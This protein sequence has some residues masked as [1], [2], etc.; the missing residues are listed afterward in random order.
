MGQ[1]RVFLSW[2]RQSLA[3]LLVIVF[4]A[5]VVQ[6]RN[7][8]RAAA[9]L[10]AYQSAVSQDNPALWY[11]LDDPAGTSGAGSVANSGSVGSMWN[12]TPSGGIGFG[13][14]S[15]AN[16]VAG[17][18]DSSG[19]AVFDGSSGVVTVPPPGM[20]IQISSF[21]VEAWARAGSSFSGTG[22]VATLL[23]TTSGMGFAGG[24]A[25]AT[26]NEIGP[27]QSYT[28]TSPTTY[29]NGNWHYLALTDAAG[30]LSLYVD[31]A[32]VAFASTPG[33]LAYVSS[34]AGAIGNNSSVPGSFFGGSIEDVAAYTA[35]LP[36]TRIVAHYD[37]AFSLIGGPVSAADVRGGSCSS[38]QTPAPQT[39]VPKTGDPVDVATGVLSESATDLLTPGRGLGLQFVRSYSSDVAG[40]ASPVGA[41]WTDNYNMG[42][43]FGSG[44][45]PS[46]VSVVTQSGSVVGFAYV[47]SSN[48][49]TAIEPRD[50]ASLVEHSGG[51]WTYIC[52]AKSV[53]D[54][55]A[56]GQLVDEHDL[57]GNTTTLGA[58][59]GGAQTITD[60]AG[61]IWTL[62]YTGALVTRVAEQSGG[63]LPAR[64]VSYSYSGGELTSVTDVNG[65]VTSYGYDSSGRLAE[66]RSARFASDGPLPATPT[67][68][69]G[70]G[71]ADAT[72]MVYDANSRVLCQWDP[73]GRE[74]TFGYVLDGS[75]NVSQTTVTDPKGN[76]TVYTF[77]QGVPVSMT[78]GFGTAQAATWM[79]GYDPTEAG[80]T[81][82]ADPDGHASYQ[83]YDPNGN[84]IASTDA[85]GRSTT[86]TYD[87]LDDVLT[88]TDADNVTTTNTYDGDGNLQSS[89]TPLL[90]SSG[91]PVL[92]G[93]TPVVATATYAHGDGHPEDVTSVT[94]ADGHTSTYT[95]DGPRGYRLSATAP[96]TTDNVERPGVAQL[97]ETL[98]GYDPV[99]GWPSAVLSPRGQQAT[100]SA[101]SLTFSCTPP[102]VGCTTYSYADSTKPSGY[103]LFGHVTVTTDA[104]GHTTKSTYDADQNLVSQSDGDNNTTTTVFDA[105]QEP[106]VVTRADHSTTR[107]DYN[108]DGTTADTVDGDGATTSYG[109]DPLGRVITVTTPPSTTNPAGDT[110]GYGYDPAGNQVTKSDPGGTCPTW[111]ITYP[112]SLS[113]SALCT[114]YG[115]DAANEATSTTYS[116][117]V[118]PDI[119]SVSYDGDGQRSSQVESFPG[120]GT[121]TSTW[122]Y[123]SL[124]HLTS[125]VDDNGASTGY[126][127][128]DSSLPQG[129]ELLYGP[130]TI[131]YPAP[132]GT[133]TRTYDPQGRMATI[134]DW[135]AN[136]TP[137][138]YDADSD[139]ASQTIPTTTAVT[140]TSSFDNADNLTTIADTAAGNP[141]PL[142]TFG[143]AY[144]PANQVRQTTVSGG[145]TSSQTYSYTPLNQLASQ[146]SSP[147]QYDKAGNLIHA[148]SGQLQSFNPADELQQ[149]AAPLLSAGNG[150][151]VTTQSGESDQSAGLNDLGELGNNTTTNSAAPVPVTG[152]TATIAVAAGGFHTLALQAD[153]TVR[154]WGANGN[155]QLGNATTTTNAPTPV[156]VAGLAATVAVSAGMAHSLA[157]ASNGTVSAWGWN[158][159][160]NLGDGNLTDSSTP[161]AVT[162]L[163]GVDA[164]AAGINYSLALKS[165]G[166]VWAWGGNTYGQ[167]G[168]NSTT[169]TDIPVQVSGLSGIVAISAGGFHALALKSDGTV[170]AWGFN[171]YGQLGNTSTTNSDVPV[172]VSG[173][174]GAVSV[175]AG[176]GHSMALEANGTVDA[177]G[178][179][180]CG[181]I[182]NGTTENTYPV[183][184][185]TPTQ[186]GGLNGVTA[187]ASGSYS[188]TSLALTATGTVEGWGDNYYG[189]LGTTTTATDAECAKPVVNPTVTGFTNV[190]FG[191]APPSEYTSNSRGD[192]TTV[193]AAGTTTNLTYDQANRLT[194]DGTTA[195][196][197]YNA[198]GLRLSKT[199]S[200]NTQ[201]MLWDQSSTQ[202]L[203]L[204]DQSNDYIYGPGAMALEQINTTTGIITW[205][206][207]DQQG[208]IRLLTNNNGMTTGTVTYNPYGQ[209]TN[210]TGTTTSLGYTGAY[211][212]TETGYIY[213]QHRYYDPA[214]AQFLTRDP[215]DALTGS[216]YSYVDDNP[217][218]GSDPGGL[219]CIFSNSKGCIGLRT[220]ADEGIHAIGTGVF[221]T[222]QHV[223]INLGA[224]IVACIGIGFQGGQVYWDFGAWGLA[225]PG[226]NIDLT[227]RTFPCQEP[228]AF[229][230]G[231]GIDLGANAS[232]GVKPDGSPDWGDLQGGLSVQPGGVWIGNFGVHPLFKI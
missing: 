128:A 39:P 100:S 38:P 165:N 96:A 56:S 166:T 30:A 145:I 204:S 198:D 132:G 177:W 76:M 3:L 36:P 61:R 13:G 206:H 104:D 20:L 230:V 29:N 125:A 86:M 46:T 209:T 68:C 91:S 173:L 75:G 22:Y 118:T 194:S 168:N 202:A 187:I 218:N 160:G 146:N 139:L 12:G 134:T 133:V 213:L 15:S 35:A 51:T 142:V 60:S 228:N 144:D 105:A 83:Q 225:S 18:I 79:Y 110:T 180:Y 190:P 224:C 41:G 102:A 72:A 127:Y 131:T 55:S 90:T 65:G 93:T 121:K 111:P 123:D 101:P 63:A 78:E 201:Q 155:G 27:T 147:W 129:Q 89:S 21:T 226:V 52:R 54:F 136:R 199:V 158:G 148:P 73:L 229:E 124:H 167:L 171:Y 28:I 92:N 126:G 183:A 159:A 106:T 119:T 57:D 37:A 88:V 152:L 10:S 196:Y 50:Q 31:G 200:G 232:V 122:A 62:T 80:V 222:Y 32:R 26:V 212:D 191:T 7:V 82:T 34:T 115:Y 193:T 49:F 216:A 108:A 162:G 231:G 220:I 42:L 25:F 163:T 43:T 157:L 214:T 47:A 11:P 156:T 227:S 208:S 33:A 179:N 98:Y 205:L 16:G 2:L 184:H 130:T 120:F 71:P 95:Y 164:I 153:G 40:V 94:D 5:A 64:S 84:V 81:S 137:F 74:T 4:V 221:W 176:Y 182:G 178:A 215:L 143:D 114:V 45:P 116:D 135:D 53:F 19:S 113:T 189:Q 161:K 149:V 117:G 151:T 150:Y 99:K 174:S 77:V 87:S 44:T 141:N 103:D 69:S 197:S 1:R 59:S 23:G 85:L 97:N 67:S 188:N 8:R 24:H 70:P 172:E 109:Y 195:T 192:R 181:Q 154:A 203:L 107:T 219:F 48:S 217:L 17:Q 211:T 112:P 14:T 175:A 140:D 185:S 9:S 58:V 6:A 169:N 138:V 223:N 186:V 210:T 170:W 66:L 207:H